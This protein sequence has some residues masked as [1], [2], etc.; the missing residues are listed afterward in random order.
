MRN[1]FLIIIGLLSIVLFITNPNQ[2]DYSNWVGEQMKKDQN[3]LIEIGVDLAVVPYVKEN[4]T[5][6]NWYL[7]S[8]YKTEIW[9]GKEVVAIGAFNQFILDQKEVSGKVD[10]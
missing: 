10:E 9:D 8:I 4:T 7:F 3:A 1:K 2:E 5:R 6:D